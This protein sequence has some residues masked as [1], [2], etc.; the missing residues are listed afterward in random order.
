[1]SQCVCVAVCCSVLQ[2]VAALSAY[3]VADSY[4]WVCVAVCVCCS[5]CVLQCVEVSMCCIECELHCVC[6]AVCCSVLQCFPLPQVWLLTRM[7]G[8]CFNMYKQQH[9]EHVINT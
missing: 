6:V 5:E 9:V 8:T 2:C 4:D 1:M 7:Y 3:S